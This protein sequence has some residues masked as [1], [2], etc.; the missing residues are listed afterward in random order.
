MLS[1]GVALAAGPAGP[2]VVRGTATIAPKGHR[3]FAPTVGDWDGTLGGLRASFELVRYPRGTAFGASGYAIRDLVYQSPSTCPATKDPTQ[4]T[5]VAYAD[6]PPP[7]VLVG[8]GGRFPFGTSSLYGS[9]GGATQATIDLSY[10]TGK[11]ARCSG[12]LRFSLSPAHRVPATDGVWRLTGADGSVGTFTVRA[13]GRIAYGLPLSSLTA[14]CSPGTTPGSFSGQVALFVHPDG[15]GSETVAG[16]GNRIS[17]SLRFVTPTTASG[18][19]VASAPGCEQ[20]TL[21]FTAM[22]TSG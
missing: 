1:V 20:A 13:D 16:S 8:K 3:A 2:V 11:G 4:S 9:F 17:L 19:Y 5:F 6:Q 14:Q 7:F 21:P 15:T 18:E 10:S 22:R 12:R